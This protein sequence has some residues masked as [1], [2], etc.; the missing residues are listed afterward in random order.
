MRIS[1]FRGI[2][3]GRNRSGCRTNDDGLR[4]R[5]LALGIGLIIVLWGNLTGVFSQNDSIPVLS[6]KLIERELAAEQT[7]SYQI[8]LKKDEFIHVQVRHQCPSVILA[9]QDSGNNNLI[10]LARDIRLIDLFWI[11]KAEMALRLDVSRKDTFFLTRK[12]QIS[13]VERRAATTI[14]QQRVSAQQQHYECMNQGRGTNQWDPKKA[15]ACL[16]PVAASWHQTGEINNEAYVHLARGRLL[17]GAKQEKDAQ[18]AFEQALLSFRNSE[19]LYGQVVAL[20]TLGRQFTLLKEY[21]QALKHFEEALALAKKLNDYLAEFQ[22]MGNLVEFYSRS[23]DKQRHL[24]TL[25]QAQQLS[26]IAGD[27][28]G[29]SVSLHYMGHVYVELGE[30]RKAVEYFQHSLSLDPAGRNKLM[31]IENHEHLADI[32]GDQGRKKQALDYYLQALT[33]ARAANN[34][35]IEAAVL[36]SIVIL[37]QYLGD[38]EQAMSSQDQMLSIYEKLGDRKSESSTLVMKGVTFAILGDRP[39]ALA[40]LEKAEKLGLDEKNYVALNNIAEAYNKLNEPRKALEYLERSLKLVPASQKKTSGYAMVLDNFGISYAQLGEKKKAIDY[41]EQALLVTQ[42]AGDRDF[43]AGVLTRTGQIYADLGE[44][45]KALDYFGRALPILQT[46]EDRLGVARAMSSLMSFW[47]AANVPL[48]IFYGKRAVNLFQELRAGSPSLDKTLH[49]TFLSTIEDLYRTLADLLISQGRIGEAERVLEMLKEEEYFK[50]LRRDRDVASAMRL[51]SD[52]TEK[53]KKALDEYSRL[54]DQ[55]AALGSELDKLDGERLRLPENASFS[56]QLRYDELKTQLASAIKTFEVFNRQLADEFGKA[57]V[58]VKELESGLQADLKNWKAENAV[59]ISTIASEERL[60]LIV[61]TPT[62]QIPHTVN[63]KAAELNRLV[64]EFRAAVT[65]PCACLDPRPAGQRLYDLLIKPIEADLKGAKATT[66][67]WSL[68][69]TLRYL[70]LGVL[71]DGRQYLVERF[72][73]VVLTLASRSKVAVTPQ[74]VDK[75]RGLGVGVSQKWQDFSP[76]PAVPDELRAIIR[77]EGGDKEIG[78][79]P[80]RRLLDGE[81]TQTALERA[82]GRYPIIHIAS[83]FS[84]EAGAEKGSFLLLGDGKH[85]TLD[86]VK[87]STP[88]FS[89]VELLTLSACNTALGSERNGEEVEGLGMLAQRQGALAV[90]A[91]LWAVADES[92]ARLMQEFYRKRISDKALTKAEALRRAQLALLTGQI[93]ASDGATAQLQKERS[94]TLVG[95]GGKGQPE[96]K[97]LPNAPYAH[98]YYWA[99]F[100]LIGNW[101]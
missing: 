45:V 9:L 61:T 25:Q 27:L 51:R 52:L 77:Q 8:A 71:W 75:W 58:R 96:F 18:E 46:S 72:N 48:A 85:Y 97:S 17:S 91:S 14:D 16:I 29:E 11:A 19:D 7:Q 26:K 28:I 86:E 69:G 84:F 5:T 53:E 74:P 41:F 67:L 56:Q 89:G 38:A 50:Y 35:R 78:V 82:L 99:P 98:P 100:I 65:N 68:D 24:E 88:L 92:T 12:Y 43:E 49:Q 39:K 37:N 10:T 57:N 44:R 66:L 6:E 2:S 47:Q 76:L 32:Y 40:M 90:V 15:A 60:H 93:K 81:F 13:L 54:A 62:I 79:V 21:K 4:L 55:M 23:G 20:D 30:R 94:S 33:L 80:G 87:G 22:T 31:K 73:L 95:D 70:P 42:Q 36:G 101:R 34:P 64:G 63:I 1:F 83:H 3:N 59:I